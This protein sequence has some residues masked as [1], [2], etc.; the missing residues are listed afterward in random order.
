MIAV[1]AW[2]SC[3][4]ILTFCLRAAHRSSIS[5]WTGPRWRF[6]ALSLAFA[7]CAAGSL[8]VALGVEWAPYLLTGG[9][10]L[11]LVANRRVCIGEA[12]EG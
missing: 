1:A 12:R 6:I 8:G 5:A 4:V 2:T 10:A 3:A 11:Y 9:A 7:A